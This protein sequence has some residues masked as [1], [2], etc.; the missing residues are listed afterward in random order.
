[1]EILIILGLILLNGFFSLAEMAMVSSRKTKLEAQANKGSKSAR[2]TLKVLN[3]P[4]KFLSTIQIGVTLMGIL[5]GIFSG[6][7]I[8]RDL[9][10]F[11]RQYPFTFRFASPLSTILIVTVVTYFTL[12]FGE[13][14]PK[15]IGMTQPEKIAQRL[16]PLMDLL[17]KI[18]YPFIWFLSVSTQSIVKLLGIKSVE[19]TA[20]EEE[21]KAII[22]DSA[23]HGEIEYAEQEIIERVFHL[24]DRNITSLMTH[25][26]DIHSLDIKMDMKE[27]KDFIRQHPHSVFPV[28]DGN[29]DRVKGVIRTKDI[30]TASPEAG[31]KDLC[32]HA[33]FVPE[34]NSAYQVMELFKIKGI[35]T[36]F[37]VD[38]Y[39]TIQGMVTLK[40]VFEAIVGDMPELDDGEEM[41]V[42][43]RE[44]G[45]FWV[46][47]QMAFYDFLNYFDAVNEWED[48]TEKIDT[49]AGFVLQQLEHIPHV[50]EHFHW[51]QFSF[52]IA[53]MDGQRI[54]KI[55]VKI[56]EKE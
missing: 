26:S 7:S 25:R 6:E 34:N 48:Q 41:E 33:L 54:D 35:H 37:I 23:E 2:R 15:K 56:S 43:E 44:D 32:R 38:E 21:I 50:G 47:A 52:E 46:D 28:C 55:L 29:I 1:M 36:C 49:L 13:L 45:S 5:T 39:G 4:E 24:G 19:N 16:T 9:T 3:H 27:A 51:K 22:S 18:T 12:V 10:E 40:D 53:D 30:F 14:V 8:Q 31:L 17:A 42:T 11:F 20:S